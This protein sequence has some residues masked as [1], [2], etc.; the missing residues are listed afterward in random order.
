MEKFILRN[1]SSLRIDKSNRQKK[2]KKRERNVEDYNDK[3]TIL[4]IRQRRQRNIRS[5]IGQT[6][7]HGRGSVDKLYHV[8]PLPATGLVR[9]KAKIEAAYCMRHRVVG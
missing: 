7:I 5:F 8:N 2:K 9:M 6:K 3:V 4:K 1:N